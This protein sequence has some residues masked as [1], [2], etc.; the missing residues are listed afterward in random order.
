M[1]DPDKS[2]RAVEAIYHEV[3]M[4][5][6]EEGPST[7]QTRAAASRL[8]RFAQERVAEARRAAAARAPRAVEERRPIR[9]SL[10]AMTRDA[11]LARFDQLRAAHPNALAFG[12]LHHKLSDAI[13]DDDLRSMID[14][15]EV[16]I[17]ASGT[18]KPKS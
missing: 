1:R 16:A 4:V 6:A 12:A 14:D 17:E 7:R 13:S 5:A 2:I 11:L 15:A 3:A 10:L 18:S 8:A 9:P